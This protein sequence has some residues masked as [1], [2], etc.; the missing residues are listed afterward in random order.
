MEGVSG[1][2]GGG[3]GLSRPP[4]TT[5]AGVSVS[6]EEKGLGKVVTKL[7]TGNPQA[8]GDA[9]S[10]PG[11]GWASRGLAGHSSRLQRPG[12]GLCPFGLARWQCQG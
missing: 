7:S 8:S 6:P 10:C 9:S 11:R 1:L 3:Q 5:D 4:H 2:W 12:L